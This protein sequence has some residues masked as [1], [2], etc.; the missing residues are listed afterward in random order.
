MP[1]RL[2]QE[3]QEMLY[4]EVM[5]AKHTYKQK[6]N[7]DVQDLFCIEVNGQRQDSLYNQLKDLVGV[8][9]NIGCF[10]A[11]DFLQERVKE[12]EAKATPDPEHVAFCHKCSDKQIQTDMFDKRC[13]TIAGC[14]N[15]TKKEW[16]NKNIPCP[17]TGHRRIC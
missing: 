7:G 8:A 10:D 5:K 1:M 2:W 4:N 14:N 6:T 11:A 17:L 9:N 16:D 12:I 3:I 13:F 15:M